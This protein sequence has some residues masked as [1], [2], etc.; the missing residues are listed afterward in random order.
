M[1]EA[2]AWDRGETGLV[3]RKE[4]TLGP[5]NR[6]PRHADKRR[7]WRRESLAQEIRAVLRPGVPEE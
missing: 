1:I 7:A 2:R 6:C 3:D 4:C 5:P